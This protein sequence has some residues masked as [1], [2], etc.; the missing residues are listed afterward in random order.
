MNYRIEL[1]QSA[2]SFKMGNSIITLL[3]FR[4]ISYR[5]GKYVFQLIGIIGFI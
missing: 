5:P 2:L 3:G 4:P 1:K